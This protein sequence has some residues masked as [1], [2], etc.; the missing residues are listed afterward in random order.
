MTSATLYFAAPYNN[1]FGAWRSV[2]PRK[3]PLQKTFILKK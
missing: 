3:S 1:N 2:N